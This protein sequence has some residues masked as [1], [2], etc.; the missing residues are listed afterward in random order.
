MIHDDILA[1]GTNADRQLTNVSEAKN[2]C[3]N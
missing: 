2:T 1:A 3:N